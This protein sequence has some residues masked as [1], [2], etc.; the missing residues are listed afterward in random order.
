LSE[1]GFPGFSGYFYCSKSHPENP[2]NSEN[3]DSDN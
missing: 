3:P 2:G 1:S